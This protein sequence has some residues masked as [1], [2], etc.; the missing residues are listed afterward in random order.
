VLPAYIQ[1]LRRGA[2]AAERPPITSFRQDRGAP[3]PLSFAQERYWTGRHLEARSVASTKPNLVRLTGPLDLACLGRALAAVVE[4][5]EVLRT[6][7]REGPPPERRPVQV[8]HATVPMG[9]PVVD[10]AGVERFGAAWQLAEIRRWSIRDGRR[11]FDYERPPLFRMTLFR[12]AAEDHVLLFTIHHVASDGWS[13]SFLFNEVSALYFAFHHGLPSPLPPLA[14]QFQDFAR[15]QRTISS[16]DAL[17]SQVTFWREHLRGALPLD[18]GAG[19]PRPGQRTFAAGVEEFL[20][21]RELETQLDAF[22]ARHG[23]T[24][25]MTLLAAFKALLH[26]ATGSDDLVVPCSFGNRNQIETENLIGNFATALPL[27]T[28]LAGVRTFGELLLR[29]RD[30]TLLA[31]DHPDIFWEP[32]AQG[33]SFLAEGDRGGLTTFRILFEL[34]KTPSAAGAGADLHVTRLFV[35]TGRISLDLSLFLTQ[36]DRLSGRFRYNRDVLDAARVSGMLDRWLRILAAVAANPEIPLTELSLA[37]S[38][39]PSALVASPQ[40]SYSYMEMDR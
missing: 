7:F 29:V 4:R 17:A 11:H 18:L 28:R 21:P 13:V 27:R 26:F 30:E 10:L 25:F 38:D 31:Q 32:V 16:G 36:G 34:L 2:G 23:V 20:V 24:L 19:G 22:S 5:H 9:L 14:A 40:V 39:R 33:M 12:C 37:V 6:T 35:D 1:R 3:P 15:W 8:I